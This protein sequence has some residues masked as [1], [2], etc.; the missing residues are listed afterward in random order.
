MFVASGGG[1]Y[2]CVCVWANVM[3]MMSL[4]IVQPKLPSQ[5]TGCDL[6]GKV[7]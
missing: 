2:V 4:M 3:K 5:L 6:I 7:S 1:V